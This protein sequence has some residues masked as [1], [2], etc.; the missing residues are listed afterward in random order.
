MHKDEA[1]QPGNI[2]G[3]TLSPVDMAGHKFFNHFCFLII[4]KWRYP[5]RTERL[6]ELNLTE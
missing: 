3:L 5:R 2:K 4:F 1:R 6:T